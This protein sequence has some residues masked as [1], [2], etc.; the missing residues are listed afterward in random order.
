MNSVRNLICFLILTFLTACGGASSSSSADGD[1][2]FIARPR[3]YPRTILYDTA[4]VDAD[5]PAD[6]RINAGAN[7]VDVTP[8]GDNVSTPARWID[9]R[10]PAYG[11]TIHCTFMPVTD[12]SRGEVTANRM[13]RMM[14]NIGDRFADQTEL[15]S[16]GGYHSTILMT[17]A[18]TPTP[19]Q[20]LSVGD[21]W[22]I[23]GALRFKAETV[24]T[25]SVMPILEAVRG[26]LIH[27]AKNLGSND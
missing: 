24:A 4:Y 1:R 2:G 11:A 6:F 3:A 12:V 27:A 7:V 18:E 25:D 13:E 22:V 23:N 20:F 5:L 9:I 10:Y 15:D 21:R 14:L 17:G 16:K 8:Q 19:V 26:D